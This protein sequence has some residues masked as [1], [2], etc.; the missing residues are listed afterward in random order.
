MR[1]LIVTIKF[2]KPCLGS[3]KKYTTD[4]ASGRRWPYFVMP[5]TPEGSVRFEAHWWRSSM[6]FAASVLCRHQRAV[7]DIHFDIAVDGTASG[8]PKSYYKRYFD[9]KRFV[10]HEAFLAGDTV[11]V[12]CV[13][14][15]VISDDD[16]GSLMDIIGR[17]RGVSPYGPREYGFFT[18]VSVVRKNDNSETNGE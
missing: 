1:E 7:R 5:R 9:S 16:L 3:V 14:P 12:H 10:R 6:Q 17:F 4:S 13:V 8:E 18:V 15:T 2:T 11:R